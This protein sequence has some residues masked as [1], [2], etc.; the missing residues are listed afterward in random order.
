MYASIHPNGLVIFHSVSFRDTS[1]SEADHNSTG[2]GTDIRQPPPQGVT[3]APVDPWWIRLAESDRAINSRADTTSS[4]SSNED[5]DD[6]D[7]R[8][9][10]KVANVTITKTPVIRMTQQPRK[11]VVVVTPTTEKRRSHNRLLEPTGIPDEY[12]ENTIVY[13][14]KSYDSNSAVIRVKKPP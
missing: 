12:D 10:V 11:S 2:N 9:R 8:V 4:E 1:S 14:Y 13:N 6:W 3:I 7:S 5:I